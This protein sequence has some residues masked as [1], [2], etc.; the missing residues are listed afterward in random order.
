[1]FDNIAEIVASYPIKLSS[2][3]STGRSNILY[4]SFLLAK[5]E[6]F[7]KKSLDHTAFSFW[8]SRSLVSRKMHLHLRRILQQILRRPLFRTTNNWPSPIQ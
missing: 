5:F 1:M 3:S 4:F 7:P 2:C 6:K 8:C